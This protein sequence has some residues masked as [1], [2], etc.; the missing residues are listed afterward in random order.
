[1]CINNID[2]LTNSNLP[3]LTELRLDH[4][5]ITR[6]PKMDFIK[7]K[8]IFITNNS[9]TDVNDFKNSK[10]P[11]LETLNIYNNKITGLPVGKNVKP[12][13]L[14]MLEGVA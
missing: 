3:A 2:A 6:L 8:Q 9:I 5:R 7:L 4:N 10:L 11:Q 1:M 13:F 12:T 14:F